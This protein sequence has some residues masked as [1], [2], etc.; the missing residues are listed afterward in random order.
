MERTTWR[1]GDVR[2][3]FD[4]DLP[5]QKPRLGSPS[6]RRAAAPSR[7]LRA[8]IYITNVIPTLITNSTSPP[9]LFNWPSAMQ[10]TIQVA[11]RRSQSGLIEY[12]NVLLASRLQLCVKNLILKRHIKILF[13]YFFPYRYSYLTKI[14]GIPCFYLNI[15]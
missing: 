15:I 6:D 2:C 8:P 7:Q 3:M 14:Q 4:R 5:M 13:F 10:P 11:L 12:D 1:R 9:R